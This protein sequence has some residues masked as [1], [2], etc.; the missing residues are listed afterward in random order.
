MKS[1]VLAIAIAGCSLQGT[2]K[3][4]CNNQVDCLDGYV[5]SIHGTCEIPDPG[6]MPITTC[7]P[8]QC[9]TRIDN[10]CSGTLDCPSCT[11][12]DHCTNGVKDPG[13]A[14]VDC[15]QSCGSTCATGKGCEVTADCTTGTC[16]NNV[17]LAGRWTTAAPM[18]TSRTMLGAAVGADG[19]VYAIGGY[20][21]SGTVGVNEVYNPT[22]NSWS[23]RMPMPTPRYGFAAVLAPDHKIWTIGGDYNQNI[24]NDGNSVKVEAYDPAT[25]TWQTMPPLPQGR[26]TPAAAVGA[27]GRI[28]VSGGFQWSQILILGSVVS[29]AP[30]ESS[31]TALSDVMTNARDG[32]GE[33]A[34]GGR[35]YVAGGGTNGNELATCEYYEPGMIG[36]NTLAPLPTA[37]KM[38]AASVL[39]GNMYVSG[40]NAW[41]SASVV[42]SK[43][44][45]VLAPST[46]TWH[47]AA[48]M[49]FGRFDHAQVTANGKLYLFGGESDG[50]ST[51]TTDVVYVY[52]PD[53]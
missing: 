9:G 32:H 16:E 45:E 7:S 12:P 48:S 1:F 47:A 23:T 22:T 19:L 18:P 11:L 8:D 41:Q 5:C 50:D 30:G 15:G 39:G 26:Y 14:D 46:N 24:T 31:W 13:E 17:C 38:T 29:I 51:D 28:Y 34:I 42:Y 40:G 33:V 4:H 52:T 43:A 37:R 49:P 53:P 36:W 10:G 44:L 6:C 20:T 21:D 27:D 25:N 2:D 35:I 3:T